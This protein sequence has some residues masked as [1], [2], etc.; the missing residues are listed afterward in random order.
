MTKGWLNAQLR[1]ELYMQLVKQ[2][3]ENK[4]KPSLMLGW[5]L[6]TISLSFFPPSQKLFPFLTEYIFSK[7]TKLEGNE[8]S[9]SFIASFEN[10]DETAFSIYLIESA[11]KMPKTDDMANRMAHTCLKRL[12]RIHVTGAKKGLKKPT[13]DEILLS[14]QTI[15]SPSLFGTTLEE[16]MTVQQ[17]KC[18]D[19]SLPWIQT[20]LSEAVLRLNGSKTEGI[21]RVPGD[22]D[23]VNNLKVNFF[24]RYCIL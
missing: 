16:I 15:T 20:T 12:E 5:E 1:D 17:S 22:L 18:P 24:F 10:T 3:T 6:I 9:E 23:E 13:L 21:F 7:L 11:K 19:L 2:T 14:R 8:M 4:N